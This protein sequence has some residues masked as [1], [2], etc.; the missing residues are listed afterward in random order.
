MSIHLFL[1][2]G[3]LVFTLRDLTFLQIRHELPFFLSSEMPQCTIVIVLASFL[4]KVETAC[5]SVLGAIPM[6]VDRFLRK[7]VCMAM[8]S[9]IHLVVHTT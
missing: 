5:L 7:V 2:F 9:A 3:V 6:I 8:V 4:A 1:L